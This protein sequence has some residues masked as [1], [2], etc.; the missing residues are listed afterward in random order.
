M[1]RPWTWRSQFDK[2]Y[3]FSNHFF[4]QFL[5]IFSN[6]YSQHASM[7]SRCCSA[8]G[9]RS[10]IFCNNVVSIFIQKMKKEIHFLLLIGCCF[11]ILNWK[12]FGTITLPAMIPTH[13]EKDRK[14][15]FSHGEYFC[16]FTVWKYTQ[17]YWRGIVTIS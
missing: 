2:S 17:K 10:Q 3:Q 11:I 16:N 15:C 9:K 6:W 1:W 14:L 7:V 12:H 5:S 4:I 13:L 8:K